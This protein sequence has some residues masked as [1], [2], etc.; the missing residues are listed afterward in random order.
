MKR[1]ALCLLL[2]VCAGCQP[3][4][5]KPK[6]VEAEKGEDLPF[7][8]TNLPM[9]EALA[10]SF[11]VHFLGP[12]DGT[13]NAE[14]S[15]DRFFCKLDSMTLVDSTFNNCHI[16]FIDNIWQSYPDPYHQDQ[17]DFNERGA[18]SRAGTYLYHGGHGATAVASQ[19]F[20]WFADDLP[21]TDSTYQFS[22]VIPHSR[23][24]ATLQ[25]G[26]M[27]QEESI[28]V[29]TYKLEDVKVEPLKRIPRLN[30]KQEKKAWLSFFSGSP[31][32]SQ[33]AWQQIYA[34]HPEKFMERVKALVD[35]DEERKQYLLKQLEYGRIPS[36]A[37]YREVCLDPSARD[38][39]QQS[40]RILCL[41]ELSLGQRYVTPDDRYAFWRPDEFTE[42]TLAL[43]KVSSF[44]GCAPKRNCTPLKKASMRLSSYLRMINTEESLKL[45][46]Q[47]DYL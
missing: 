45:A 11:T 39:K 23:S 18:F 24:E 37:L 40:H 27:W 38:M 15:P 16:P 34:T 28:S 7:H 4:A 2:M 25:F 26:T 46:E 20:Q 21:S 30:S 17:L 3:G 8:Y 32:A 9:H 31:D 5:E 42:K 44:G 19:G 12:W 29:A 43:R 36:E 33:Q 13:A 47:I 22:F 10:V 41:R 6:T 1:T 35:G 14:W